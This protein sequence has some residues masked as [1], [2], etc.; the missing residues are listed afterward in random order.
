[1]ALRDDMFALIKTHDWK[2]VTAE[3]IKRG[4]ASPRNIGFQLLIGAR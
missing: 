1:M 4:R 3:L 2:H